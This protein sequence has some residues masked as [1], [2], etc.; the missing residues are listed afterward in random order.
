M[1][2]LLTGVAGHLGLLVYLLKCPTRTQTGTGYLLASL[3]V[4]E[5]LLLLLYIP[6]ELSKD[7]LA[8]LEKGGTVC[9][10]KEYVKMLTAMA[11][12]TNMVAVSF[13]RLVIMFLFS[14]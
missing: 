2:V 6:L 14:I 11:S 10:V 8:H 13:E 7:H 5:L 1:V 3:S 9:K 12:V 4:A